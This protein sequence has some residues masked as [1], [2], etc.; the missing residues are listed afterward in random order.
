VY[1]PCTSYAGHPGLSMAKLDYRVKE[2]MT[3]RKPS[4]FNGLLVK[5]LRGKW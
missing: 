4:K 1:D 3:I 2:G 5:L